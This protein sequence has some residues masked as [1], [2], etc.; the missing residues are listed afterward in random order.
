MT[1]SHHNW[2]VNSGQVF[3]DSG[4]KKIYF[5]KLRSRAKM[6]LILSGVPICHNQFTGEGEDHGP[7]GKWF[8]ISLLV[9]NFNTFICTLILCTQNCTLPWLLSSMYIPQ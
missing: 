3:G 9:N 5:S 7:I 4:E 6:L 1:E 8:V 2:T